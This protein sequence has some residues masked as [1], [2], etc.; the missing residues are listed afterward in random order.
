MITYFN[1]NPY[2]IKKQ[3]KARLTMFNTEQEIMHQHEA[4]NTTWHYLQDHRIEIA[5]FLNDGEKRFVFMGCGS[6]YMMAKMAA[7]VFGC[8]KNTSSFALAGGEYLVCPEQYNDV[9]NNSKLIIMSR[10]G[11]TSEILHAVKHIRT[12]SNTKILSL[13]MKEE[14]ELLAFSDI[15]LVFPWAYDMSVCQTR[16]VTNFYTVIQLLD[17]FYSNDQI[18]ESSI[19]L[20]IKDN[21]SFKLQAREKLEKIAAE[22]F[23]KAIVLADGALAGLAEE[24][25]LAFTEIAML[26]GASF[27]L[28]DYRHGPMILQNNQVLTLAVIQNTN[29]AFQ[30]DMLRD[31]CNTGSTV[32]TLS[33]ENCDIP[34]C[35]TERFTIPNEICFA[36]YGIYFIYLAQMIAFSKA[37][38][39]GINPDQPKGLDAY[40]VLK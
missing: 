35:I 32:V 36:A 13:T 24:A 37:L 10:S 12:N 2:L 33:A 4:L 18:L 40:I 1:D 8:R 30:Q 29:N 9:L 3:D 7:Y 16:T 23:S 22:S 17:A 19:Y 11:M 26:P 15:S 27:H 31:L 38:S 28:L 6:S 21:E 39:A 25:A 20:A 5:S 34:E 14:N